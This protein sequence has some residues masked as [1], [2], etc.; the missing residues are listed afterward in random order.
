MGEAAHA[1]VGAVNYTT[2]SLQRRHAKQIAWLREQPEFSQLLGAHQDM[3]D[4]GRDLLKAVALRMTDAKLIGL[5]Q[6]NEDK[7]VPR[8]RALVTEARR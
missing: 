5:E 4:E 1:L 2:L 8:I 6:R 7:R 3:T